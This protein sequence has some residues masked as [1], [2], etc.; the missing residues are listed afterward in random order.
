M[1]DGNG[2]TQAAEAPADTHEIDLIVEIIATL[3]GVV[4]YLLS[5]RHERRTAE[6]YIVDLKGQLERADRREALRAEPQAA[7]GPPAPVHL[8]P[9]ATP[10][11]PPV[12]RGAKT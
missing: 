12:K 9:K 1:T 6:A 7:P 3:N 5:L 2:Q 11:P 10:A 8:E 4:G